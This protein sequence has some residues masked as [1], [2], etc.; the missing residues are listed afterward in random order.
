MFKRAALALA[1]VFAGC[2]ITAVQAESYPTKPV[3]LVVPFAPG[4]GTDT[5]ARLVAQKLGES[6]GTAVVV[7]NKAGASGAIGTE[8]VA[9]SEADG[10]TLLF[11]A[12]PFT[13]VAAADPATRYDPVKQFVPVALIATGPLVWV[14]HPQLPVSSLKE[15]AA[16]SIARPGTLAYG[17]AGSGGINHLALESFK[18]KS[19]ADLLHTPYKGIAPA[20]T[21]LLGG[22]IHAMTGTIPATLQYIKAGKLKPLAVLGASR[23]PLL[24]DVPSARE[25]G[26]A[27]VEAMNYWGIVAP[28][29]TPKEITARLNTEVQKMLTQPDFRSRMDAEGVEI[30]PGGPER[31]S[32][33]IS[34]DLLGWKKL[35]AEA[36]IRFE[37]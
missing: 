3:K 17:S 19:G 25:A 36:K 20:T 13:T 37:P 32:R 35:V 31:L 15:L 12:S 29:G 21:D 14:V 10:Y 5:V 23:N 34:G 11:V 4:A 24:P 22:Q 7:E 6:L 33:L 9:K 27:E 26:Y 18:A 28:A 1:A 8:A 30:T 16:L 2:T